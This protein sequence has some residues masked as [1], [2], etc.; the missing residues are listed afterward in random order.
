M[1]DNQ[2]RPEMTDFHLFSVDVAG[3]KVFDGRAPKW[4]MTDYYRSY[5]ALEF[6]S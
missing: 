6:S 2:V 4:P 1:A 3:S 5:S